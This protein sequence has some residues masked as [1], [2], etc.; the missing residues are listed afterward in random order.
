[1]INTSLIFG[2]APFVCPVY[3]YI[4]RLTDTDTTESPMHAALYSIP[5]HDENLRY[6]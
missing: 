2:G 5:T 3:W 1:M 4:D 6:A